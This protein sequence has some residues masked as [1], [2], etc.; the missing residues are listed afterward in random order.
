MQAKTTLGILPIL[1]LLLLVWLRSGRRGLW[2]GAM[3]GWLVWGCLILGLTEG[4]SVFRLL[5]FPIVLAA[6]SAIDAVLVWRLVRRGAKFDPSVLSRI[7][8]EHPLTA[9]TVTLILG[10]TLAVAVA[11]P[12]SG[13]DPLRCYMA[14]VPNWIQNGSVD[15]YPTDFSMQLFAPP[16]A[17]YMVLH[18]QILAGNDWFAS[19][20]QW[21]S[22]LAS[23][24]GAA[25]ITRELG[26]SPRAMAFAAVFVATIPA[27]ILQAVST[28][29]DYT[30]AAWLV[31]FVYFFLH[32]LR[33]PTVGICV[34]EGLALGLAVLTKSSAVFL[35][36]PFLLWQAGYT[37]WRRRLGAV[38]PGVAL[39]LCL[40]ATNGPHLYRNVKTFGR[41]F[42]PARAAALMKN[43]RFGLGVM[44]SNLIR[45]AGRH[46]GTSEAGNRVVY[47]AIRA[48]HQLAGMDI[49]DPA[50]T[51][52]GPYHIPRVSTHEST[53]G[54][55]IHLVL[56]VLLGL[57]MIAWRRTRAGPTHVLYAL[58]LLMG[59]CL[60]SGY[61]KWSPWRH[62]LHLPWFVLFA[63][64]VAVALAKVARS[65]L[66]TVLSAVLAVCCVPWLVWNSTRPVFTMPGLT[67]AGSVFAMPRRQQYFVT[68]PG[69]YRH[70]VKAFRALRAA[71]CR[72]LALVCQPYHWQ[73]PE[74]R[75]WEYYV[76]VFAREELGD[77]TITKPLAQHRRS[78]VADSAVDAWVYISHDQSLAAENP[79]LGRALYKSLAISV[80]LPAKQDLPPGP[81]ERPGGD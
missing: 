22:M 11:T 36:A 42:A 55:P 29:V 75:S 10:V 38:P 78:E 54:N 40:I 70:Y 43:E 68:R 52:Y 14:R 44:A 27:G 5:R 73:A 26:G 60:F 57:L 63:P 67:R 8:A 37:M 45:G 51:V 30:V 19:L 31:L 17:G 76:W 53:A 35:V 7:N 6:W 16:Q 33:E 56:I 80:Y 74:V 20:P 72:R 66:I 39:A 69:S 25:A 62:R 81:N 15:H 47:R 21:L 4:L 64:V 18:L 9:V 58:A 59:L 24:V 2:R 28:Y 12:P 3:E 49:N 34:W 41:P 77:F 23:L 65:R 50:T 48:L 79:R 13:W 71:D 1:A 46:V 32:A 61:I